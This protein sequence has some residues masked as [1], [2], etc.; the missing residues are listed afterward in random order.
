MEKKRCGICTSVIED[1]PCPLCGYDGELERPARRALVP[2]EELSFEKPPRKTGAKPAKKST[3]KNKKK[4]KKRKKRRSSA[5]AWVIAFLLILVA[6]MVGAVVL[7]VHIWQPATCTA[8]ETCMICRKTQ[9]EPLPHTWNGNCQ[10]L[11]QCILCGAPQLELDEHRWQRED[12]LTAGTCAVCGAAEPEAPGHDWVSE[13][14]E[15]AR[16]C[17]RCGTVSGSA[18]GHLWDGVS[19]PETCSRCGITM[20]R[21]MLAQQAEVMLAEESR[22]V[23][24][25]LF[26]A[27]DWRAIYAAAQA[28]DMPFEGAE[29]YAAYM[30]AREE[31]TTLQELPRT[32]STAPGYEV[33]MG[34]DR[35]AEFT[36]RRRDG[37]ETGW[38]L[39]QLQLVISGHVTV[40]VQTR[41][42]WRVSVNGI[43]LDDTHISGRTASP[44][45]KYLPEGTQGME[46][47][48][49]Q[50]SGLMAQ[51]EIAVYDASGSPASLIRDEKTGVYNAVNPGSD[52]SDAE[53]KVV[54]AALESY[55]GFMINASGARSSVLK[56]FENG[57]KTCK[58]ILQMGSELWM[59][60]DRGHKFKDETIISCERY[61]D[62]LFA[63]RAS[64]V[65]EANLKT[66]GTRDYVVKETMFFKNSGS[67]VC[68][69]M[70]NQDVLT[71]EVTAPADP[72]ADEWADYPDGIRIEE[73]SG[74]NFNAHIML[75]RDP[76]RV[77]MGLSSYNGFSMTK[78]GKRLTE[79]IVDEGAVAAVNAGAFYDDGTSDVCVG[80]TPAGLNIYEG[81]MVSNVYTGLVPEKGF[82]GLDASNR[83]V[84]AESMT[85]SR[86]AEL[87]IQYGCEFGPVLI[88]DSKINQEAYAKGGY[89]PRTAVGQREDGTILFVC[90]DGRQAGSLGA[91]YGELI[92]LLV[93]YGA[94]NACNMDGGSS[95]VMLTRDEENNVSF[96]NSYSVLQANPRRMPT[97]WLV[98]P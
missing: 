71:P 5:L 31:Q 24:D 29:Q 58:E 3:G 32:D 2:D 63:V 7:M 23:Y 8:P 84:V 39:N 56:Y 53:Q 85:E 10:T 72:D 60:T 4:R 49:W 52:L 66:G 28:P 89:N 87:G 94:V 6:G 46:Y 44:A 83:L 34:E 48:T 20:T 98:R 76:S 61:S 43:T 17:A 47:C 73:Y 38:E 26:A 77:Y 91:T 54:F 21:E 97:F 40:S 62:T 50:V 82:C 93:Q 36:L 12:C 14:C 75:V 37:A 69:A 88:Q 90:A 92:D 68:F 78:A 25:S 30:S 1:Y 11:G 79:A 55:S 16:Y 18:L 80:S 96:V 74:P 33:L 64:L 57:T 27:P 42:G 9:G 51:P 67:W 59:N 95:T 15:N 70:T 86:A 19:K 65:L 35:I 22:R 81:R 13:D 45:A 41:D